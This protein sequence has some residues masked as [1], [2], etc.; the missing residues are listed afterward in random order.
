M[1]L[2]SF[3]KLSQIKRRYS[4]RELRLQQNKIYLLIAYETMYKPLLEIN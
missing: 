2:K 4:Y 1:Y 3:I